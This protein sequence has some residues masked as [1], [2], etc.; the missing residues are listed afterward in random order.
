[1]IGIFLLL[2][3]LQNGLEMASTNSVTFYNYMPDDNDYCFF[4]KTSPNG[5]YTEVGPL[6]YKAESKFDIPHADGDTLYIKY[7]TT[8]GTTCSFSSASSQHVYSFNDGDVE[9]LG[10][11]PGANG[12]TDP[13]LQG[14]QCTSNM[15]SNTTCAL[16][17]NDVV[18]Q[19]SGCR[20]WLGNASNPKNSSDSWEITGSL[21]AIPANKGMAAVVDA[22]IFPSGM[23]G[24]VGFYCDPNPT[25]LTAEW[26][27]DM[28]GV[29]CP[30][31]AVQWTVIGGSLAH[32]PEVVM[33]YGGQGCGIEVEDDISQAADRHGTAIIT[34][35]MGLLVWQI[36]TP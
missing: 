2:A 14:R 10:V 20:V 35:I 34:T 16:Y 33:T 4:Y 22:D 32:P 6:S 12:V 3:L 13:T 18:G 31:K 19:T 8:S 28:S 27:G 9:L 15:T 30:M 5:S 29:A 21:G 17:V 11:S 24:Y 26:G 25:V 7:G 36:A 1:M 23:T